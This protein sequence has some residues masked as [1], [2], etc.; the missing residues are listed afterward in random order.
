MRTLQFKCLTYRKRKAETLNPMMAHLAKKRLIFRYCPFTNTGLNYFGPFNVSVVRSTEK[1]WGFL[2][3]CLTTCTVLFEVVPSM[4]N[5]SCVLG[6]ERFLSRRG[7][8]SVVWSIS[9]RNFFTSEKELLNNILNW[10][11]HKLIETLDEKCVKRKLNPPSSPHHDD[12]WER[13]VRNFNE[14]FHVVIG[15]KS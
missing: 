13:L 1:H 7:V 4:D 5:S 3:I 6:I 2:F 10:N 9:G 8:P 11:Q 14:V 15:N 12:N